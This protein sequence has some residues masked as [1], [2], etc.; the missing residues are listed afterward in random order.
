[1][2]AGQALLLLVGAANRDPCMFRDPDRFDL[3]RTPNHH[4]AF[5]EGPHY[6]LGAALA[7]LEGR[8]AVEILLEKLPKLALAWAAVMSA[9]QF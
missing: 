6:C 4:L 7:R 1:M 2:A 8:M 3:R 5:G 9:A